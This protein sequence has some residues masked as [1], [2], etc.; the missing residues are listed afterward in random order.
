MWAPFT[1]WLAFL[2]SNPVDLPSNVGATTL[3]LLTA[4]LWS[5]FLPVLWADVSALLV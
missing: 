3:A 5:L 1:F 4:V 2:F